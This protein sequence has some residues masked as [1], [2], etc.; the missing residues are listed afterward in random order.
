M[1]VLVFGRVGQ[2]GSALAENLPGRYETTFLDQPD[3]DLTAPL[4]L[5][6]IVLFLRPTIVINAAAYTAVDRAESEAALVHTINADAPGVIA[7][8]CKEIDAVLI[9]YS[10]DYVFDGASS[11]PYKENA[12]TA[13]T[14]VYGQSKLAGEEAIAAAT[15]RYVILRTAWLYSSVG[16]NFLKTMLRLA[17]DGSEIRVVADQMGSP[18]YAW[19]LAQVTRLIV[20]A[21]TQG[22]EDKYGLYHAV[23]NG[24]TS[25]Y[26]FANKIFDL[27]EG[28]EVVVRAISTEEYPTPAP[29]P[30]FSVLSCE[31]LRQTFGITL[32]DWQEGVARCLQRLRDNN[33]VSSIVP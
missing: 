3:I 29:R 4:S 14:S 25:W 13:P 9:H 28:A 7:S 30:R 33:G 8:A 24:V 15:E 32:P 10:T 31:H 19:D 27:I 26:G 22:I 11:V 16:H 17:K 2:L 6:E 5:R 23:N 20:D 12:R 18:T 21:I 1:K